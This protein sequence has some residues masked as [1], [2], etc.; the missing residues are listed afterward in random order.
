MALVR[1]TAIA[2][3]DQAVRQAAGLDP[4]LADATY[5]RMHDYLGK[6]LDGSSH[7][8]EA[9]DV[10]LASHRRAVK[11]I[12]LVDVDGTLNIESIEAL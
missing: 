4:D 1:V 7:H 8:T 12:F 11:V 9:L 2:Y 3:L 10:T 6:D 5:E